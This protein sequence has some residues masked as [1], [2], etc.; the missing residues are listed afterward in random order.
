VRITPEFIDLLRKRALITIGIVLFIRIGTFFPVPG[1]NHNDLAFYIQTHS[2]A[3]SLVNTFSGNDTFIIGLFTLNIFPHINASILI[4]LIIGLSPK[5]AKLQKEGDF[6]GRRKISSLTRLLTLIFAV[7]QSAGLTL[8]LKQVLFDWNYLLAFEIIVWLTTGAMIVLWF[9]D[10]ITD[11]GLGNGISILIYTNIVSN[12]PN[13]TQK[14]FFGT[15]GNFQILPTLIIFISLYGIVFLQEGIRIIPLISS[16]QL[17]QTTFQSSLENSSYLPL[18][19]NQAGVMPIILTTALLVVPN[20]ITN[21]GL[22]SSLDLPINF[23]SL[24]FL[25]WI[26]Y[27]VLI[28]IFSSFYAWIV[29]NPKD[30]SDQLQRMAVTI[31]GLR[32]G[33]QTTFYLKQVMTRVTSLGALMLATLVTVPNF[34]ESLL[35]INSLSE[36]STSSLLILAGVLLDLGREVKNLYYSNIYNERY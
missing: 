15:G 29:L 7:I 19:F 5:L 11:Y 18:R 21:L 16:K 10:L 31:P 22:F 34:L 8:Y 28:L 30:I 24:K 23:D 13:L 14:L 26:I 27:F 3:K 1:I 20:Y 35:N 12:L 9:S 25:Y 36:L 6:E 17:N 4:Q 2:V 32:P 33:I